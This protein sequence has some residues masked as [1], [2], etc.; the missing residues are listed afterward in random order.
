MTP[1]ATTHPGAVDDR[2]RLL[3]VPGAADY[4]GVSVRVIRDLRHQRLLPCVKVGHRVFFRPDDLDAYVAAQL[5][6]AIR[7]PLASA[8]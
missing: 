5:E 4:L 3:D 7:G 8:R 2:P 6:P 1:T